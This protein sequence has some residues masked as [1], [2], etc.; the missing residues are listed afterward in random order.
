MAR[1]RRNGGASCAAAMASLAIALAPAGCTAAREAERLDDAVDAIAQWLETTPT[2]SHDLYSGSAGAALFFAERAARSGDAHDRA[3]ALRRADELLASLPAR[4]DD[5]ADFGLY[6]G[7]AGVGATLSEAGRLLAEPRF[8]AGAARSVALLDGG[9]QVAG[10]GL[11]WSATTDVIGGNAGIGL[12]LLQQHE[13]TGDRVALDL[14]TSAGR[15]L[16]E[17]AVREAV[18]RSWRMDPEFPRVMPNFAHGT[19]GIAYFLARLHDATGDAMFLDAAR[20]GADHLLAIADRRD[21]GCRIHHHTPDG[22]NLWYLGWCH[23]PV[24]TSR[25]FA[26]LAR[27]TGDTRYR[28][29]LA[30]MVRTLATSGLPAPQ[31][32]FWNNVGQCCGSAGVIEWLLA[33]TG[34][35]DELDGELDDS[36]RDDDALLAL[37]VR[38]ADDLLMRG[39]RDDHGLSFPHAESRTRPNEVA[40]Q[41]GYMQGA[42]GIGL[43]LLHLAARQ[44][45]A[46][47]AEEERVAV[48]LPDAWPRTEQK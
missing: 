28:D 43:A 23:G 33:I 31:P 38:L 5:V 6:T 18:G 36:A 44:R 30:G 40:A 26:L 41:A 11:E 48:E 14:A 13:R 29:A 8:T 32:G 1:C 35:D 46:S 39:V 15:R 34:D 25:L 27:Q 10:R 17:L 7:I 42:S 45:G 37:A 20:D 21:G 47:R 9:A 24:G 3:I 4:A 16:V 22:E 19:A 12:F 2:P